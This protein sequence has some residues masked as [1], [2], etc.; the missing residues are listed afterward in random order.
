MIEEVFENLVDQFSDP[1]TFY[2]ELIQNAMD[3]G[4]NQV[5]VFCEYDED[6]ERVTVTVA[7]SGEGMSEKVIDEQLTRLFSSTK[8]NDLTKIGK[9]GIG[10]VSN[11]T[12]KTQRVQLETER[13][14]T[15]STG[16]R[17]PRHR[18]GWSVL[19]GGLSGHH[20]LSALS[21]QIPG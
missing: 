18:A 19:A 7:D 4:S 8:E 11:Y 15:Y 2:R 17:G 10:F 3:A 14:G 20:P 12:I 6:S 1:F 21:P 13:D 9:F 16:V 5:D